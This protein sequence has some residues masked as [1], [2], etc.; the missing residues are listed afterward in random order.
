MKISFALSFFLALLLLLS[1]GMKTSE[2]QYQVC[3]YGTVEMERCS[4]SDCMSECRVK[5]PRST[6]KC[7]A[8]D[9]CCCVTRAKF[10]H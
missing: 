5:V 7:I 6:G 3:S 9:T 1:F 10:R 8:I 4:I 2:A